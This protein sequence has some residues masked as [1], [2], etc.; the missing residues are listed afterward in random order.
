MRYALGIVVEPF[1]WVEL[2]GV[3]ENVGVS[4]ATPRIEKAFFGSARLAYEG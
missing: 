3:L 1:L 2:E 4:V